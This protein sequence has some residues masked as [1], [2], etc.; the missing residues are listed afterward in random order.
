[1]RPLKNAPFSQSSDVA[2]GCGGEPM[3]KNKELCAWLF[4]NG[5]PVI[6]YRTATELSPSEKSFD[7]QPLTD[8]MLQSPQVQKWFNNLIPPRLLLNNPTTTPHVLS[9]GIM[10]V[11]GSKPDNLENVLGK[12]TDFGVKKGVPELD[13]RTL[14]YRKWLEGISEHPG[15]NV[16]DSFSMGMVADFLSRAARRYF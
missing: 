2:E 11:H 9:S 8:A 14:P 1:M 3:M 5:G 7:I 4:E 12:L 15:L 13:E 16:F 6:R 10:E